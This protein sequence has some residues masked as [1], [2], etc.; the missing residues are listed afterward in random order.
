V[1]RRTYF[2]NPSSEPTTL[3]TRTKVVV[4]WRASGPFG[5]GVGDGLDGAGGALTCCGVLPECGETH[6][7]HPPIRTATATRALMAVRMRTDRF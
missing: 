1:R 2:A 6:V 7:V 5:V 4:R 3:G